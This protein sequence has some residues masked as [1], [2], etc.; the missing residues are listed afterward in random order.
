M[1]I[2][3]LISLFILNQHLFSQINIRGT[4]VD[5]SR[6]GIGAIHVTDLKTNRYVI[7]DVNGVFSINVQDSLSVLSFTNPMYDST[8]LRLDTVNLDSLVVFLSLKPLDL[9]PVIVIAPEPT[10]LELGYYG[11]LPRYPLGLTIH[12]KTNHFKGFLD[13]STKDF[14]QNNYSFEIGPFGLGGCHNNRFLNFYFKGI[15]DQAD[16]VSTSNYLMGY[17]FYNSILTINLGGGAQYQDNNYLDYLLLFGF[18]KSFQFI[19]LRNKMMFKEIGLTLD[20]MRSNYYF[21][22]IGSVNIEFY[23]DQY[24]NLKTGIGYQSIADKKYLMLKLSYK[25]YFK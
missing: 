23:R 2:F 18:E 25:H 5:P 16:T 8:V 14:N 22:W 17:R 15:V 12:F 19:P 11:L 4:T 13:Y 21:D 7:S 9:I 20:F 10:N 3:T 6:H 24:K 1:R